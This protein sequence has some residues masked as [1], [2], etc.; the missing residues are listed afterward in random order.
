MF[1]R[2][3]RCRRLTVTDSESSSLDKEDI[4]TTAF[5]GNDNVDFDDDGVEE[6]NEN[7]EN[8][9]ENSQ[10]SMFEDDFLTDG[11]SSQENLQRAEVRELLSQNGVLVYLGFEAHFHRVVKALI[12]DAV[13]GNF[14]AQVLYG[15][16]NKDKSAKEMLASLDY[17]D[18][19]V[20]PQL[21]ALRPG[22]S[23]QTQYTNYLDAYSC[24]DFNEQAA[25]EMK[26]QAC[27][28]N[29]M[30]KYKITLSGSD[31]DKKTLKQDIFLDDER[32]VQV[33]SLCAEKTRLYH[34]LRHFKYNLHQDCISVVQNYPANN[35]ADDRIKH[36]LAQLD[37]GWIQQQRNHLSD[38]IENAA[39]FW[40]KAQKMIE[41][42]R[43]VW[44]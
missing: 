41:E 3:K 17:L 21:G 5:D 32:V 18:K 11:G 42:M 1:V 7:Q 40:E 39:N 36:I 9:E 10:E 29:R 28:K 30:C 16:G 6:Y 8:S 2:R 14:L 38:L 15:R 26:C 19:C 22:Y 34:Q 23:W 31:Y 37:K 24:L 4:T 13:K 27:S 44:G 33:G 35:E 20:E 12:T 25:I 43:S